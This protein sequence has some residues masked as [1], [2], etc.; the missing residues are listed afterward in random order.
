MKSVELPGSLLD[1]HEVVVDASAGD[2][3]ALV[4]GDELAKTRREPEG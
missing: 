3:G 1:E 2:E 4:G